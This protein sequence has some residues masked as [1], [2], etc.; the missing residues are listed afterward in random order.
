MISGQPDIWQMK[1]DIRQMKPDIRP[2]T[3]YQKRPDIRYNPILF[4]HFYKNV[5]NL[6]PP[7]IILK[8]RNFFLGYSSGQRHFDEYVLWRP[9]AQRLPLQTV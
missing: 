4:L 1:P 5:E 7:K 9:G 2:D 6:N 3:G 8:I